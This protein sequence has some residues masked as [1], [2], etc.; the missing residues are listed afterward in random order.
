MKGAGIGTMIAPGVGTVIGGGIG[1]LAGWLGGGD[2]DDE[3]KFDQDKA[4]QDAT[5]GLM[6]GAGRTK[7]KAQAFGA[8]GQEAL[9]PS[10]DY[11]QA[12]AGDDPGALMAA[13]A[14]ERGRV[15]DQYD[16]AR[17][18]VSSFGPRGGGTTSAL[19]NSYIQEAYQTS[20]I[21]ATGRMDANQMLA[22]MGLSLEG[23]GLTAEQ[24]TT[25]NLDSVISAIMGQKSIDAQK[26]GQTM[27]MWGGIGQG[28]GELLGGWLGGGGGGATG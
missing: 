19:A 27:A 14:P 12:L 7:A 16:A 18:A 13:T 22:S 11:F 21:L 15:M 2:D 17:K 26:R 5:T 4:A 23:L 1:A 28:A 24:L 20:D 3:D 10:M 25:G 8:Q 9:Q 6:E